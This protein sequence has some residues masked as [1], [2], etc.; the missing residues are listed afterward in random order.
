M[1]SRE[2]ERHVDAQRPGND[3]GFVPT[4]VIH[5]RDG[6]VSVV[7]DVDRGGVRRAIGAQ[8]ASMIPAHDAE[9]TGLIEQT[10]PCFRGD[11]HAIADQDWWSID[12][13]VAPRRQ[14]GAVRADEVELLMHPFR[15]NER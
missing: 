11:P 9:L 3:D 12:G 7:A 15:V 1:L 2:L 14:A 4:H 13:P 10:R 5:Q 8:G 6:I